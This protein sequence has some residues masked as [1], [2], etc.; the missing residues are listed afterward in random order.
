[1]R[2]ERVFGPKYLPDVLPHR[3]K[4]L[5][6]LRSA[7]SSLY[8]DPHAPGMTALIRG[9][10]G[11]GKTV[12]SL[13]FAQDLARATG[14]VY[15]V[16]HVNCHKCNSPS[17]VMLRMLSKS[18]PGLP[19]RGLS[20]QELF[21]IFEDVLCSSDKRMFLVLDDLNYLRNAETLIYSLFRVQEGSEAV[22]PPIILITREW[23]PPYLMNPSIGNFISLRLLS[24]R[25]FPCYSADQLFDILKPRAELGLRE[26]SYDDDVLKLIAGLAAEQGQGSARYAINLLQGGA[27]RAEMDNRRRI[28]PEHVRIEESQMSPSLSVELIKPLPL[29]EKLILLGTSR[30]LNKTNSAWIPMGGLEDE[31]QLA[32]EEYGVAPYKHTAVWRRV[33]LLA[34]GGFIETR[35]SGKGMRGQTTLIG[36]SNVSTQAMERTLK[37][38]LDDSLREAIN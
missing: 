31:Y 7:F 29:H 15:E 8:L 9:M 4:E 13:R 18:Y 34:Q 26:G 38:M 20:F 10:W 33:R 11:V 32:C 36:V 21:L 5:K 2:N 28:F 16:E 35:K 27:H 37:E 6:A 24:P 14:D 25:F 12:V 23:I 3:E 22:P 30:A 19:Q 1:M 17:M